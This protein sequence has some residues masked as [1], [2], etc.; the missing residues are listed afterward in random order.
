MY[1][2][3]L[4]ENIWKLWTVI[5]ISLIIDLIYMLE[6]NISSYRLGQPYAFISLV[7]FHCNTNIRFL[8]LTNRIHKMPPELQILITQVYPKHDQRPSL[9]S[10]YNL[11]FST[12]NVAGRRAFPY[13]LGHRPQILWIIRDE[14]N[15]K[16]IYFRTIENSLLKGWH[17][18]WKRQKCVDNL[19]SN[20]CILY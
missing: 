10:V 20:E 9:E 15:V 3:R 1:L 7:S 8:L 11:W 18:R 14:S 4:N 13:P 19:L 6:K 17:L 12:V 5:L 2:C 16:K